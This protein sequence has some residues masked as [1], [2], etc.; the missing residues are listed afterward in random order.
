[1]FGDKSLL[2]ERRREEVKAEF[3]KV[4]CNQ[5]AK[6]CP[7]EMENDWIPGSISV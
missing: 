1:M 5:H 3:N 6:R 2:Q 7:N 4:R